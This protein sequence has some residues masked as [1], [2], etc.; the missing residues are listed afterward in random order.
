MMIFGVVPWG[1]ADDSDEV[2]TYI[3]KGKLK[4]VLKE[5]KL[6]HLANTDLLKLF[7]GIFKM[8]KNR[9]GLKGIKKNKWLKQ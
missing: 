9:I 7:N 8:E 2:F 3:I 1:S 5:W 6:L 4:G